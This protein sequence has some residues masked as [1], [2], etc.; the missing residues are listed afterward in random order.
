MEK[1][2]FLQKGLLLRIKINFILR[3]KPIL[4]MNFIIATDLTHYHDEEKYLYGDKPHPGAPE[5]YQGQ[6]A[7]YVNKSL[8]KFPL[9]GAS[10]NHFVITRFGDWLEKLWLNI[11][12]KMRPSLRIKNLAHNLFEEIAIVTQG[13]EVIWRVDAFTLDYLANF[14]IPS[15][16]IEQYRRGIEEGVIYDAE[17]ELFLPLPF[18]TPFPMVAS[19]TDLYLR[20]KLRTIPEVTV[21]DISAGSQYRFVSCEQR[22]KNHETVHHVL[23]ETY[24][25]VKNQW[26]PKENDAPRFTTRFSRPVKALTFAV[27]KK[28]YLPSEFEYSFSAYDDKISR[29]GITDENNNI[30]CNDSMNFFTQTQP[31][32][33][34]ESNN[35]DYIGLYSFT[36]G[37][38]N[39][40][41]MTASINTS[42]LPELNL[43]LNCKEDS[44]FDKTEYDVF[45]GAIGVKILE[46]KG[47]LIRFFDK[48]SL[49]PNIRITGPTGPTGYTGKSDGPTGYTGYTGKETQKSEPSQVIVETKTFAGPTTEELERKHDQQP[50]KQPDPQTP[51]SPTENIRS[52]LSIPSQDTTLQEEPVIIENPKPP[53]PVASSC[54][55]S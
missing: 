21:V 25:T 46:I 12:V 43:S 24:Q 20:Y 50:E 36:G 34:A 14:N 32:F 40:E 33:H 49:T 9:S 11:K 7:T 39:D 16:K 6:W 48:G 22:I 13:G 53:E 35:G 29:A 41:K 38:I 26:I 51:V 19:F 54:I 45:I 3:Y 2:V 44:K 37:K 23:V 52:A 4:K 47:G 28:E 55:I 27:K 15:S 5:L 30:R 10:D 1:L 18:K 8:K 42:Y 31:Y 17:R